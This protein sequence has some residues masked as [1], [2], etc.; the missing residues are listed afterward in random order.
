MNFFNKTQGIKT[1]RDKF[2]YI[3]N[4]ETYFTMNSWNGL[5]SI[6]NNVKVYNL[7]LPEIQKNKLYDFIEC[8]NFYNEINFLIHHSGLKVGF[9]GRSSGYLVLYNKDNNCSAVDDCYYNF[10]SY[11]EF[12]DCEKDGKNFRVAQENCKCIIENDFNLVK[13][14][15]ILCDGI[16]DYIIYLLDN[17]EVEEKERMK[18][19][20]YMEIVQKQSA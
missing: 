17:A 12:L 13:E 16:R 9:N 18:V 2:N 7:G 14:F 4:H 10:E 6:A 3:K 8:E 1:L 19:E 5:S 11:K 15:D 20:K